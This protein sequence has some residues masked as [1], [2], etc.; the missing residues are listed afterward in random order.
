MLLAGTASLI[1]P[2]RIFGASGANERINIGAI[3]CGRQAGGNIN[4]TLANAGRFNARFVA[5]CDVDRNRMRNRAA[6]INRRQEG[7]DPVGEYSDYRE[8]LER[9]DIDAVLI[10]TP[11]HTHGIIALDAVRA[12]KDIYIEKPL[13]YGVNEGRA[14]VEAVRGNGCVLQV[15]SQQRSS[16]HFRRVCEA[17]RAGRLGEVNF[18]HVRL[19]VDQG[20][21]N[22]APMDVPEHFDY[23]GWLRPYTDIPYTE[24]RVH[25]INGF[26][27]PG[28]LQVSAHCLGMI[29][30][31]GTHMVDSAI[32][33]MG[34]DERSP[35][36]VKG[37]AEFPDRGIFDV[38]TT[39]VADVTFPSGLVMRI[40]ST[41]EHPPSVRFEGDEAWAHAQRGFFDASDRALL[42]EPD[43]SDRLLE[44]STDHTANWL[45]CIRSRKTPVAPV[46]QGHFTNTL[47]AAAHAACRVAPGREL[48]WNA[49]SEEFEDAPEANQ[50]L[51]L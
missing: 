18:I 23:E 31:W 5:V 28:F 40:E 45:E 43:D 4:N 39:L 42:A 35:F 36:T 2:S 41:E 6:M 12:G 1:V 3:G 16:V 13:T 30:G 46:E 21:G 7:S 29:T 22:A 47:C 20:T 17:V 25:P 37:E 19:P 33:G 38:H 24:D 48:T 10:S 9:P 14:L 8:L 27:R 26:G 11:D 34:L 51:N 15:G 49:T 50:M 44:V 32:W